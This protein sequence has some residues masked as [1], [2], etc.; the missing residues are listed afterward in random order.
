MALISDLLRLSNGAAIWIWEVLG[1]DGSE[2]A[3]G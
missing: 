2:I 3:E 1:T